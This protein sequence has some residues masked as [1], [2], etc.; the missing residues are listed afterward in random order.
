MDEISEISYELKCKII[1]AFVF[2][3]KTPVP[4]SKLEYFEKK[5]SNLDLIISDL[6]KK[7]IN[8]GFN[9]IKVDDCLVFR[10]SEEVSELLN[11]EQEIERPLS[12]A[13]SETLAIIAYHQ[14]ITRSKIENI[15]GVSLSKGTLDL[16][17]EIGWIKPSKRLDTHGRPLTWV[18]TTK[19]LD[20]FGL[21]SRLDLPGLDDLNE[22]GLLDDNNS[23]FSDPS[24]NQIYDNDKEE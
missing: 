19:F 13:A 22:S 14:P 15:R 23:F 11:I 1:E 17:F 12:R 4:I 9:L 20:H 21:S 5:K 3:S 8:S 2:A 16:L 24:L 6:Q 18:T 7:H 10:T